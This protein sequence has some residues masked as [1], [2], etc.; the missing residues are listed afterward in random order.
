[1][2][3]G[4]AL[5]SA[6]GISI[7]AMAADKLFV[8]T[9][10]TKPASFTAEAEGPACDRAGNIY[11][12][13]FARKPTIGRITPDGKGEVFLEMPSG[14]LGNGIRFDRRG[15]MYVADYTGHNI[16]RIDPRTKKVEVFANEPRMNQPNDIAISSKGTLWASDP[17]WKMSKGQLWRID[18]DRRVTQLETGM[19]TTNGIEVSPD[20]RTLYVNESV[21]RNVWAYDIQS[22]GSSH[23]NV[24]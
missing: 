4:I 3:A 2:N 21:Q 12:V 7:L 1:M 11:A 8:A 14:S 15:L 23:A 22:D 5:S 16:L 24:F 13:S 20:D 19:G 9:P 17:D 18:P 10:L 6:L